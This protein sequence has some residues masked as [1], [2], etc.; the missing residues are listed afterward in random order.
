[1][2]S[3]ATLQIP[4]SYIDCR[5]ITENDIIYGLVSENEDNWNSRDLRSDD[6]SATLSNLVPGGYIVR[7][8]VTN[9][10]G[11]TNYDE[12]ATGLGE[13]FSLYP[14][15]KTSWCEN[16]SSLPDNCVMYMYVA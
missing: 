3:N 15:Q 6:T 9:R 4:P 8:T 2:L 10:G 11:R 7:L 13:M 14:L 16:T 5:R 12:Q 1:M